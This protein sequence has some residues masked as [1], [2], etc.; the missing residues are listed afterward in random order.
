M[1]QLKRLITLDNQIKLEFFRP[2]VLKI[3]PL[4]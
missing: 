3:K 1:A 4:V 2:I